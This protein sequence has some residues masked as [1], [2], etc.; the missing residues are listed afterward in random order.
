MDEIELEGEFEEGEVREVTMHD[1]STIILKKLDKDYDPTDRANA[2]QVLE[3][4]EKNNWMVTGLIYIDTE[5]PTLTEMYHL[6]D[7]PL[8]RLGEAELRP[9]RGTIDKINA[10]MF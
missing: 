9:A 2:Y 7:G 5:K 6:V 3:E 4:A 1:G 8:N 10:M